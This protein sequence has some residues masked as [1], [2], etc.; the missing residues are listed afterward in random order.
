MAKFVPE[1]VLLIQDLM[2][3][4]YWDYELAA[5]MDISRDTF[6]RWLRENDEFKQAFEDGKSKRA[7]FWSQLGR[8]AVLTDNKKFPF[9]TWIAFM[10]NQMQD[11]GWGTGDKQG[12]TTNINIQNM[13]VL[14]NKDSSELLEMLQ[15]KISSMDPKVKELLPIQVK[16]LDEPKD[17]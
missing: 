17:I 3:K 15:N 14:Q 5:T 9:Q 7:M 8:N 4:G 13:N 11:F 1:H 2:A 10:N 6:Y 12:N 16:V